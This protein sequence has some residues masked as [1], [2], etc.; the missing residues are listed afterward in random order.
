MPTSLSSPK[1]SRNTAIGVVL[2][3]FI[4]LALAFILESNNR[5]IRTPEDLEAIYRRP[6]LGTVP[7][8][9]ALSRKRGAALPLAEAEAFGLIR[10]HLRFFNIDRDL[11]TVAIA[12]AAAGDGKTTIARWL[13]EAAARSG[14]R[15]LLLELD[16]RQP[17]LAEQ[18]DIQAGPGAADV[19]I[20]T[21]PMEEATRSV[22]VGTVS[23]GEGAMGR[24]FDVLAAGAVLPPNP[25]EL[26][27][28]H[29]M[30]TVLEQ[31]RCCIRPSRHRHA[32][33]HLRAGRFSAAY[34]GRRRHHRG[35]GRAQ[36]A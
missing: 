22:K 35:L 14:S 1:T 12:S 23:S 25:S 16:L 11:H 13:A 24:T 20:G 9:R 33:A 32:A 27:E 21:T 3:L 2:G 5:R 10:A 8:S 6:L 34:K 31:A 26:L 29:A 17:T 19:L 30:E 28:S 4:G 36:P 7:Q 15:V 18:L